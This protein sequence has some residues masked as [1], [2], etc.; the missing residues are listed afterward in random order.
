VVD[1]SKEGPAANKAALEQGEV[2]EEKR[3]FEHSWKVDSA[4][5][6]KREGKEGEIKAGLLSKCK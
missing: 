2:R 1:I 3:D 4:I 6:E 5:V